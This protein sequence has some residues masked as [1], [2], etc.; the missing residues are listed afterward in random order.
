[1]DNY[2]KFF[3]LGLFLV[4]ALK[5]LIF[6]AAITDAPVLL[7]L[8][9]VTAFYEYQFQGREAKLLH[10]RFDEIDKHLSVLYKTSQEVKADMATFKLTSQFRQGKSA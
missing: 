1:M 2:T 4:F 8:G 6:G 9:L 10:K 7:I 3:P 5:C